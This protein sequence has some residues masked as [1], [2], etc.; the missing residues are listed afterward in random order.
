MT[1][2]SGTAATPQTP[3]PLV[4]QLRE[5][6]RLVIPLGGLHDVQHV[7]LLEKGPDGRGDRQTLMAVRFVPLTDGERRGR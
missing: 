5:G 7:T 1:Q 3:E 6:G 2:N 4:E